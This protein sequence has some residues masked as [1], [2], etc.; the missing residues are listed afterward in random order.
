MK[1]DFDRAFELV[2][3]HEGGYVNNPADPGGET[4]FGISKRSYPNEDIA[5]MT[6]DR[7]KQ[8]YRIDFWDRLRCG[9][10]PRSLSFSV[11]D[12]GVNC[13]VT[14]AAEFLQKL[15]RVTVDA[16]IG[17]LT[18]EAVSQA[19]GALLAAKFNAMRLQYHA[20]LP[21]FKD[22]GKGWCR[23]VAENILLIGSD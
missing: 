23:R 17:P 19:N 12:C 10:M 5:G 1:A 22:F 7:A 3:G 6:L 14:R 4:K 18:L 15:L 9:D 8:I 16:Q 2:V 20:S 11:F 13:G 21:S